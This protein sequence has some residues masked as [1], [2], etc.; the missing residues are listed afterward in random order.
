MIPWHIWF[1]VLITLTQLLYSPIYWE[2]SH[3]HLFISI[4]R[5]KDLTTQTGFLTVCYSSGRVLK[6]IQAILKNCYLNFIIFQ[7]FFKI[8]M[9]WTSGKNNV[10]LSWTTFSCQNGWSQILLKN[11]FLRWGK[12]WNVIILRVIFING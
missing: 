7:T 5:I 6:R 8:R 12:H 11:L 9:I 3:L 2:W 4:C 10:E 1:M